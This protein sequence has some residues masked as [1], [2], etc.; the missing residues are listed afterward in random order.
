MGGVKKMKKP[1]R[2]TLFT[3][4]GTASLSAFGQTP[5]GAI[6]IGPMMAYPEIEVG[7]KRDSNIALQPDATKRADTITSIKP[8]VR[9]EAK[10]GANVYDIGYR[11]EYLRYNQQTTDNIENHDFSAN[12]NMTFDARNNLKLRLTYSERFDPRGSLNFIVTP[13]PNEYHQSGFS[14]LYTYGA[15][16]A[17]GRLEL[18]GGYTTK[19]YVSNRAVTAPLDQDRTDMGGTFLWRVQPKTYA[20]FTLRQ[21]DY[22]YTNPGSTLDSKD[23]FY[24]VGARW[25]A[26][27]ATSGRFSV[28]RQTK[29]FESPGT[30]AGRGN[31]SGTAWE[32]GVNWKPLSYSSVDFSTKRATTDSTGLGDFGVNQANQAVWTHAWTSSISSILTGGYT[33][34][35]FSRSAIAGVGERSDKTTTVGLRV[36]Y[37]IQ[38][39]LKAGAE[40]VNTDRNSNDNTADYKRNTLMFFLAATL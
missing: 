34:D 17:Q 37:A 1:T 16:D 5:P 9:L 19:S 35:R 40:Y 30:N 33:T 11:G 20:T 36:N 32:G 3:L 29:K 26:T 2:H 39:W 23:L 25:D 15:E 10:Q 13:T 7:I 21:S 4:L 8:G 6:P 18:Q 14:G 38:R 27:A 24:L 31:F 28:G 12:A 22:H